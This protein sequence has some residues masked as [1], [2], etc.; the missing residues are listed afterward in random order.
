[1]I[2]VPLLY[3][4]LQWRALLRHG[5]RALLPALLI[6]ATLV[7]TASGLAPKLAPILLFAS[8]PLALAL[9]A[10]GEWRAR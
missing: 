3:A 8:L 7:F 9:L 10:L 2:G 1:M 5:L 6:A 4:W